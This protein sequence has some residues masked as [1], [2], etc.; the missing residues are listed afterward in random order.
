MDL[1]TCEVVKQSCAEHLQ[2]KHNIEGIGIGH[3]WVNGVDTKVPAILV[4]VQQKLDK[5]NVISKYSANDFIPETI[6]GIPTDVI[7]V[8]YITKQ[9][10][11]NRI[12]PIKPG[13][14]IG[15]PNVTAGTL[16]GI[17]IDKD[18]DYVVLSN[19][20]VIADENRA[21]IGDIILQP[22]RSDSFGDMEF[23]GWKEPVSNLP[24][25]ANLK[26][27]T[28]LQSSGNKHD[29]AIAKIHPSVIKE[30]LIDFNYPE[31]NRPIKGFKDISVGMKVQKFGR[32]TGRTQ[33]T[34]MGVKASFSVAYDFGNARFED[35]I[36]CTNMSSGGDSGSI[37]FDEDMNAVGLLFAGS[38]KVTIASPIKTVVDRY[39]LKLPG[40]NNT[41]NF[42]SINWQTAGHGINISQPNNNMSITAKANEASYIETTLPYFEEISLKVNTGDDKGA[43]WGPGAAILWPGGFLKLN[44]R[45][46]TTFGCTNHASESLGIGTTIPNHDYKIV[47]KLGADNLLTGEIHDGDKVYLMQKIKIDPSRIVLRI[48]KLNG[49]AGLSNHLELGAPGTS[50]YYDLLVR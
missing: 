45:Y 34:V 30:N 19:N 10:F 9:A 12:R 27:V 46:S 37:I 16:G 4:F 31:I 44:F 24:Y 5:D 38:P 13:Y 49:Q 1:S 20:H 21:K 15:H 41:N 8:G 25:F 3:K 23:S 39:G 35:C 14:S 40:L 7:E 18:N 28:H 42:A 17:F 22:A 29:S 2:N 26:D 6:D 32:T 47:F 36:V 43:T 50:R 33:G 48:G 11:R